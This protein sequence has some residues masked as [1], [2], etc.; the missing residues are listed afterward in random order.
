MKTLQQL[1]FVIGDYIDLT[2]YNKKVEN[3]GGNF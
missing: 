1:R 2:I 3:E